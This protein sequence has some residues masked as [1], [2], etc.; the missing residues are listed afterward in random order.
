VSELLAAAIAQGV[1]AENVAM[2]SSKCVAANFLPADGDELLSVYIERYI[3][4][5]ISTSH[6]ASS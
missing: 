3:Y 5:Y 4:I 1:S 2:L 6:I